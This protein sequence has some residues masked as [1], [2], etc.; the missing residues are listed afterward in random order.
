MLSGETANGGFPAAAV[1]IMAHI[2]KEAEGCYNNHDTFWSRTKNRKGTSTSESVALAAVQ[3]S[4]EIEA[5]AIIVFTTCGE[6]ARFV[7]KYR[8]SAQILA[9]STENGTI[10]GLTVSFGVKCL[11][12][13]SF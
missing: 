10:K 1:E 9:V 11:R 4:F 7:A 8:P 2:C 6:M 5:N 13:P 3:V 12:V